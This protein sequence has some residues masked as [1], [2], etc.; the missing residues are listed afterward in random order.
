MDVLGQNPFLYHHA[1]C[2]EHAVMVKSFKAEEEKYFTHVKAVPRRLV[3]HDANIISS[4]VMY[5]K[6]SYG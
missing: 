4:H 3:P 5:K 6:H 2:F 1:Q